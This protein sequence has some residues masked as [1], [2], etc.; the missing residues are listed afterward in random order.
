MSEQITIAGD[1]IVLDALLVRY[2]G[3]AGQSLLAKTLEIN[4]GLARLGEIVPHG[5][6]ITMPGA[7]TEQRFVAEELVSLFD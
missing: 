7:P 1:N 2:Y 3:I 6:V 5:T 4:Q